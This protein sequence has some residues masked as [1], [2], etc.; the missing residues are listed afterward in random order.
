MTGASIGGKTT[1][2]MAGATPKVGVL[3]RGRGGVGEREVGPKRSTV[4]ELM[5][6]TRA[7]GNGGAAVL[8]LLSESTS[9][10]GAK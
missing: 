5:S 2:T 10:S 3:G 6:S 4:T 7:R 8:S 1:G 9:V